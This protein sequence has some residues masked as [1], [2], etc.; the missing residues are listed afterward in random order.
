MDFRCSLFPRIAALALVVAVPLGA[1]TAVEA[2]NQARQISQA[3]TDGSANLNA[4][5]KTAHSLATGDLP[6]ELASSGNLA[7]AGE[8][9]AEG[10]VDEAKSGAIPE[11]PEEARGIFAEV[12]VTYAREILTGLRNKKLVH[13][14]KAALNLESLIT[15]SLKHARTGKIKPSQKAA[16]VAAAESEQQKLRTFLN[17]G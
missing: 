17:G 1:K 4:L 8:D 12:Y 7:E 14:Q 5:I 10:E 9:D 3:P 11:L 6:D 15:E 13:A 16:A 2:K